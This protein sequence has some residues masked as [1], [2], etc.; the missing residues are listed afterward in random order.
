MK[1]EIYIYRLST[2]AIFYAMD[3]L[4]LNFLQEGK[5]K[6]KTQH[7]MYIENHRRPYRQTTI[8][9]H[10]TESWKII[11]PKCHNHR[12]PHRR[13]GVRRHLTESSKIITLKCHNHRRRHRRTIVRRH[14]TESWKIITQKCH[15]HRR[16]YQRL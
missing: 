7:L 4:S 8:R 9:R 15:N 16:Q 12:R 6:I 2:V 1:H 13:T 3:S 5:Q 14:L 11:T 10:L